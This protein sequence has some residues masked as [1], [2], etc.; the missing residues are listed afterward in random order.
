MS[1]SGATRLAYI[2][3]IFNLMSD[4]YE[5]FKHPLENIDMDYIKKEYELIKQKKSNLSS[6][7]RK[8]VVKIM[9]RKYEQ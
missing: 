7:E 2:E 9:E 8:I 6:K 4:G 3:T 5:I 1:L